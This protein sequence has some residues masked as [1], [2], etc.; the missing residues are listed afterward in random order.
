[1]F[2]LRLVLS[3]A[4]ISCANQDHAADQ[5]CLLRITNSACKREYT[6]YIE[7]YRTEYVVQTRHVVE[8]CC[9]LV[10]LKHCVTNHAVYV[11]DRSREKLNELLDS[12]FDVHRQCHFIEYNK[13]CVDIMWILHSFVFET[14]IVL[15]LI[16]LLIIIVLTCFHY[17]RVIK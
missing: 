12:Q 3:L 11:C 5:L 14:K 9:E 16:L 7:Y 17:A 6:R 10:R 4:F 1:M 2:A 15:F 8:H 13:D